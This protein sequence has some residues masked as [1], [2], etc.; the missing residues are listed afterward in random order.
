S[1]PVTD[2]QLLK[3]HPLFLHQRLDSPPIFQKMAVV[4]RQAYK[5]AVKI[6]FKLIAK[7][8]ATRTEQAPPCI[9]N[10]MVIAHRTIYILAYRNTS[11]NPFFK[12]IPTT[13]NCDIRVEIK[14]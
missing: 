9:S 5:S 6:V 3:I 13:F 14:E 4:R 8:Q 11:A 7:F 12:K 1:G 10:R 2:T